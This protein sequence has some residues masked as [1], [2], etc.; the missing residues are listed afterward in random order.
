MLRDIREVLVRY[1]TRDGGPPTGTSMWIAGI[2]LTSLGSV[3]LLGG[4]AAIGVFSR[5][6]GNGSLGSVLLGVPLVCTSTVPAGI[7]IPLWAV[8]ASR[9][10]HAHPDLPVTV[11]TVAPTGNGAVLRWAF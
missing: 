8:G 4:V 2:V 9:V 7:G 11:P 10:G 5:A 1:E 3:T 6:E